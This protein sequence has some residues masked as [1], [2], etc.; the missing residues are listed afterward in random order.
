MTT[1]ALPHSS[2]EVIAGCMF[3]GKTEELMRRARRAL[4]ANQKVV[5]FKPALD[6][7]YDAS[8]VVSHR[9]A[10]L[11]AIA[12]PEDV[13]RALLGHV[14][15]DTKVVL[16]DEAQ[17]FKDELIDVTEQLVSGLRVRVVVAGLDQDFR[18]QPFGPMAALLA[19]ADSVTKLTAICTECGRAATRTQRLVDV[20]RQVE[21]GAADKYAARC[22][23]HHSA[24]PEAT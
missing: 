14:G 16:I 12:V 8:R 15:D 5:V 6:D 10:G 1:E 19:R 9:G 13:P 22:R 20:A 11:D 23:L 2:L 21:L 4:I 18:A 24:E 7:R 17:F 3:C